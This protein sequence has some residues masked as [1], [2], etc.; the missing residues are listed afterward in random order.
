MVSERVHFERCVVGI[1]EDVM[2]PRDVWQSTVGKQAEL[3]NESFG[4]N[5]SKGMHFAIEPIYMNVCFG[6]H[7]KALPRKLQREAICIDCLDMRYDVAA[8][9]A[10]HSRNQCKG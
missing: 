4:D 3:I 2:K 9:G 5:G 10:I 6:K 7:D 8:R 1:V